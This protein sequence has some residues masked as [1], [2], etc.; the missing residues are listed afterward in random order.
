[1]WPL[2]RD[3]N[4]SGAPLDPLIEMPLRSFLAFG[5]PTPPGSLIAIVRSA[6]SCAP[7]PSVN[8]SFALRR[9]PRSELAELPALAR[10][11][12]RP[13]E[14]RDA[15]VAELIAGGDGDG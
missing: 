4:K 13:Q 15:A 1:M 10:L 12:D 8:F 5:S 6:D 11:D 7:L 2:S 9:D 14:L 3:L